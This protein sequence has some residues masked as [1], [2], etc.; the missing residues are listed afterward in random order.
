MS[1]KKTDTSEDDNKSDDS[2]SL[3]LN[4]S[5]DK[6]DGS[7]LLMPSDGDEDGSELLMPTDNDQDGPKLLMSTD[8]GEEL[9]LSDDD[10]EIKNELLA[11]I[12][13]TKSEV[14]SKEIFEGP[15]EVGFD[16]VAIDE[17]LLKEVKRIEE[18]LEDEKIE[19][20]IGDA[21]HSRISYKARIAFDT[22]FNE[23]GRVRDSYSE[24]RDFL[25]N[26]NYQII[27][28]N[29]M[30]I[31]SR[32][33]NNDVLVLACPDAS[34][35]NPY[36]IKQ[37]KKFVNNGGGLLMLSHAG[38]DHGRGTNLNELAKEFGIHFE[39]NQVLD[40]MYNYG[41]DT[42]PVISNFVE[43]PIIHEV[44]ELCLRAGC[45]ITARD[46]AKSIA[47]ANEIA[48]PT[49]AEVVAVAEPNLGRV[50]A[51]GAYEMFRNEVVQWASHEQFI[52]NALE[53]LIAGRDTARILQFL[54]AL[55][56]S[57]QRLQKKQVGRIKKIA[58]K[59]KTGKAFQLP[60]L[61]PISSGG[62]LRGDDLQIIIDGFNDVLKVTQELKEEFATLNEQ[63][64]KLKLEIRDDLADIKG[65]N[66]GLLRDLE[67][68]NIDM[69]DKA[70]SDHAVSQLLMD[71][72]QKVD[73]IL[74]FQKKLK[75]K[76]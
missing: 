22:N 43:H 71:L 47:F 46:P 8:D 1:K 34:K 45:S 14:V 28:Y 37:I 59:G 49:K 44:K 7:E 30:L 15:K 5:D 4:Q 51:I 9:L 33:Y 39:N 19:E 67:K 26:H 41:L 35:M 31:Q 27:E 54:D 2:S 18:D 17:D 24:L 53:W 10:D 64:N 25:E 16:D 73:K 12:E 13:E 23:R 72:G 32:L 61:A 21:R 60:V 76:K 56:S 75:R 50:I 70:D 62:G 29:D 68:L 20:I 69:A 66:T 57:I 36:E 63:F 65:F 48:D 55:F 3:L 38:G 74:K 6:Q 11:E 58:K 40:E 42:F 52:L